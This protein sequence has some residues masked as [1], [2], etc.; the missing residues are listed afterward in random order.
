M[1]VSLQPFEKLIESMGEILLETL[2]HKIDLTP[3][4]CNCLSE[5]AV[6]CLTSQNHQ[7]G[8]PLKITTNIEDTFSSVLWE[9]ELT[10][11]FIKTYKD[12]KR[13]TD[14]GAMCLSI[15]LALNLTEYKDFEVSKTGDGIDFW[16]SKEGEL[17]FSARLEISGIRKES[18]TNTA[19]NR[20]KVKKEQAKKSDATK[21]PA[22][23]SI[24]EFSKPKAIFVQ[25]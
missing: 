4:F 16:L 14:W 22:Y 17:D 21:L 10:E 2:Q 13:T 8:I 20:L 23:I 19:D 24:I 9:T 1:S 15:F 18:P 3:S 11:T 5:G 6:A 12:E 7:T 25:K